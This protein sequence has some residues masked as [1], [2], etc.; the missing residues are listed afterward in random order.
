VRWRVGLGYALAWT[1]DLK[2]RWANDFLR[3]PSFARF[4]AQLVREHMRA[5]ELREAPVQARVER[6]QLHVIADALGGSEQFENGLEAKGRVLSQAGEVSIAPLGQ[7]GP[8]RYETHLPWIRTG[9]FTVDVSFHRAGALQALGHARFATAFPAELE[10]PGPNTALLAQVAA[11]TGGRQLTTA[12]EALD[13]GARGV[14]L[15]EACWPVL[16][17]LALGLF[18]L[19]QCV[20]HARLLGRTPPPHRTAGQ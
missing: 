5:P 8:G 15:R 11:S 14:T 3:W 7:T 16:A 18:L 9:A 4:T 13:A 19:D 12:A 6:D 2:P 1:S 20:R 17:W 10:A